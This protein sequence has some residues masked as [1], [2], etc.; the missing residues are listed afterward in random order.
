MSKSPIDI[1]RATRISRSIVR[2]IAKNDLNLKVYRQCGVQKLSDNDS[3]KRLAAC[4]WLKKRMTD[5]RIFQTRRS[6]RFRCQQTPRTTMC[7]Q[8]LVS[9]VRLRLLGFWKAGSTSRKAVSRLGK[10]TPFLVTP[11]AKVNSVYYCE[12]VGL[13][14]RGLLSDIRQ[15]SGVDGFIFQQDGARR[16][17]HV[18]GAIMF[19]IYIEIERCAPHRTAIFL[20]TVSYISAKFYILVEWKLP[21]IWYIGHDAQIEINQV[22]LRQSCCIPIGPPCRAYFNVQLMTICA[23][24]KCSFQL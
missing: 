14:A 16:I 6:S 5:E 15:L 7:M 24:V 18:S 13:L 1:E 23:V 21:S 19:I 2:R 10:T 22:I 3:I 20:K 4:K 11:K 8:T 9:S 17:I 12:E